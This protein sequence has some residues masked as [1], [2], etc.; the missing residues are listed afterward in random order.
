MAQ[1]AQRD[2]GEAPFLCLEADVG[3]IE[4]EPQRGV[5]SESGIPGHDQQQLVKGRD[6][7]R[8]LRSIAE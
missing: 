2:D 4:V 8:K 5:E 3:S 6:P 7:L 1:G